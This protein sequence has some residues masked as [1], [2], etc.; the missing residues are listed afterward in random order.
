MS[1]MID[2]PKIAVDRVRPPAS[3][4]PADA[5]ELQE[6]P[7]AT[8]TPD[9]VHKISVCVIDV[10]RPDYYPR[11]QVAWSLTERIVCRYV[12]T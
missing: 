1:A 7:A 5:K 4:C 8:L 11:V 3:T 2:W 9:E 12:D 6:R 10:S